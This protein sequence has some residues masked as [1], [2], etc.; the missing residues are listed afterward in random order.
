MSEYENM[1]CLASHEQK[2]NSLR[3]Q[4][5]SVRTARLSYQS[6]TLPALALTRHLVSSSR[7]LVKLTKYEVQKYKPV[8]WLLYNVVLLFQRM[9]KG[10]LSPPSPNQHLHLLEVTKKIIH[11]YYTCNHYITLHYTCHHY[12]QINPC[13]WRQRDNNY[14]SYNYKTYKVKRIWP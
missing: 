4:V 13:L 3:N 12:K 8:F 10:R 2:S 5:S 1:A 11:Y 14:D 6:T 9:Q 7:K